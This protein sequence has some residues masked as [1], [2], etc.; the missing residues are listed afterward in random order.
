[1]KQSSLLLNPWKTY[2]GRPT[3]YL[4]LTLPADLVTVIIKIPLEFQG[5][6]ALARPNYVKI[7]SDQDSSCVC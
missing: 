7:N 6:A 1:M 4:T 3:K 5:S 2:L